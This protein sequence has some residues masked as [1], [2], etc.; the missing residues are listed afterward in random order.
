MSDISPVMMSVVKAAKQAVV[1]MLAVV[2]LFFLLSFIACPKAALSRRIPQPIGGSSVPVKQAT[3]LGCSTTAFL[4]SER[5]S[6]LYSIT[7][8][9][10]EEERCSSCTGS[11]RR[12]QGR[13]SARQAN[14][15]GTA[16]REREESCGGAVVEGADKK[17]NN[18]LTM[19]ERSR[20]L[21]LLDLK[22]EK[23]FSESLDM[24]LSYHFKFGAP[25]SRTAADLVTFLKDVEK[26]AIKMG[27]RPTT[28]LDASFDTAERKQFARR[29]TTGLPVEDIRLKG[30][31]LPDDSRVWHH[32]SVSGSCRVPPLRGV[33]LVVTD[34]TGCETIFGFFQF[35]E[36]VHDTKRKVAAE[37]GLKG[38]WLFQ[39]S[40]KSSD[41]RFREIVHLFRDAGFVEEEVDEYV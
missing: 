25:Q 32:D 28:V 41:K 30:A 14:D 7:H 3:V 4:L 21:R 29:L 22:K 23:S 34:E 6:L 36:I 15:S 2:I 11:A 27:F 35:P 5:G 1:G 19:R 8:G 33:V 16:S 20:I 39:D 18:L 10:N 31:D 38:R 24:G 12:P 26:E 40:V 13:E 37:T 9:K 17:L